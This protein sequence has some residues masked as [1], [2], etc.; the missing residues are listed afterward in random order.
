ME[1]IAALLFIVAVVVFILG[2]IIPRRLNLT[3]KKTA[4]ISLGLIVGCI[5][6]AP[7][8]TATSQKETVVLKNEDAKNTV[9]QSNKQDKQPSTIYT[10]KPE[11]AQ[12]YKQFDGIWVE[13]NRSDSKMKMKFTENDMDSVGILDTALL[14]YVK[15]TD[16]CLSRKVQYAKIGDGVMQDAD[17]YFL[18][19]SNGYEQM[20][21]LSRMCVKGEN[22][23]KGVV[24]ILVTPDLIETYVLT[25]GQPSDLRYL[26]KEGSDVNI[27][28]VKPPTRYIQTK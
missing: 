23:G 14:Q 18:Q 9:S 27:M 21:Y 24:N 3:R 2:M 15:S 22:A 19:I 16:K 10:T 4:L 11:N 28:G 8:K 20:P 5:V 12:L 25:D 13:P 1:A 6:V 17:S 26:V 7:S